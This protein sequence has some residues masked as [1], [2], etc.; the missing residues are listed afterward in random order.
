MLNLDSMTE[1]EDSSVFYFEEMPTRLY[2]KDNFVQMEISVEMN[3]YINNLDLT[4]ISR[5][6]YSI[7][8][9]ISDIGGMQVMIFSGLAVALTF[10]N[11]NYFDDY[12][13]TR[14]FRL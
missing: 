13:V 8:D 3:Q 6:G 5:E 2:E 14:L 10:I 1:L 4:V 11:Y 7:F 9:L 12:L